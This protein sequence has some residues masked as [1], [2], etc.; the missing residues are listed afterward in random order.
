MER[1]NIPAEKIITVNDLFLS[2]Y[3]TMSGYRPKLTMG[4]RRRVLF[5]FPDTEEIKQL[6]DE[7]D[8]AQVDLQKFLLSYRILRSQMLGLKERNYMRKEE[9]INYGNSNNQIQR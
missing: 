9:D 5:I 2:S 6:I 8:G 4:D 3:L 7:Y 1:K